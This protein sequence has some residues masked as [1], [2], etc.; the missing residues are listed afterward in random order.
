VKIAREFLDSSKAIVSHR[1]FVT[2]TGEF[3]GTPVSVTSTGIGSASAAMVV[4]DLASL[5]VQTV[6]R[7]GTAGSI[8]DSVRPGDLVIATGAVRDEGLTPN[9]VPLS[10]PAIA[11]P[12][13]VSAL[14]EEA[15][16][17]QRLHQ[18]IV[19]TSDGFRTPR[20][21]DQA[22]IYRAAGVLA[23]EM[24][25]ASVLVVAGLRGIQAGAILAIDGYVLDVAEGDV[26]P[27]G[28]AR[29]AAIERAIVYALRAV[30]RIDGPG[31]AGRP[32]EQA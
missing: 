26:R 4:E 13:V 19:H 11:D 27:D 12:I 18:G 29:D 21:A 30:H 32:S 22:H 24:E 16:V 23:F 6:V 7:V 25:T 14:V 5:G 17:E 2:F 28:A 1:E 31:S 3:E 20:L 9:Y 15:R 10:Y 8:Q